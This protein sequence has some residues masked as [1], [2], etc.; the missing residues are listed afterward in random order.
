MRYRQKRSYSWSDSIAYSV[1]LIASDGCLY[2][3]GRH[4]DLTSNDTQQLLNFSKSIGRDDLKIT[5]KFNGIGMNSYRLQFSDVAYYDFLIRAGITPAKSK[6]ISI[7]NV[8]DQHYSHF[9]RGVFDGDGSCYAYID[10]RWKNSYMFYITFCSASE[11]FIR[12]IRAKNSFIAGTSPGALRFAKRA[13]TLFYAKADSKK[14]F[15][16]MY[17]D[18]SDL[19][20]N[21]KYYKLVSFIQKDSTDIIV[22]DN[23]RVVKLVNTHS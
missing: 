23:A 18:V 19:R 14:I 4:I 2:K 21:R 8:P 11:E 20:L 3:D 9:L 13:W 6:T 10:K 15:D 22:G 1:G 5:K 7:I 17:K 16:C 12:Y